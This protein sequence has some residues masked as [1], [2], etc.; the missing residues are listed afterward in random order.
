M[1]ELNRDI[2]DGPFGV[3]VL[4][5]AT[6]QIGVV[7]NP[8]PAKALGGAS[9][10]SH[11]VACVGD[12]VD[13][14]SLNIESGNWHAWDV[15]WILAFSH[16]WSFSKKAGC[17]ESQHEATH[18]VLVRFYHDARQR[19]WQHFTREGVTGSRHLNSADGGRGIISPRRP[20]LVRR[21]RFLFFRLEEHGV[22]WRD[23]HLID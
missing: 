3:G 19:A 22:I 14:S 9:N 8:S 1:V 2:S 12:A 20:T 10:V 17:G 5:S 18:F 6:T 11:S 15:C 16:D 4:M 7:T 23:R 21:V 13:A